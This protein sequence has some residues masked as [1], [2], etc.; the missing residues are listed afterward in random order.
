VSGVLGVC[1]DRGTVRA[2]Q[3]ARGQIVWVGTAPYGERAELV[4]LFGRLAADAPARPRRVRVVLARALVQVRTS[5]G[6]ALTTARARRYVALQA[7]QLFRQN[8]S[9]LVTDACV[10]AVNGDRVLVAAAAEEPLLTAVAQGCEQAGLTLESLGPSADVL[11]RALAHAPETG[12]LVFGHGETAELL[13][14]ERGTVW[15][16]RRLL[17]TAESA[18]EWAEPLRALGDQAPEFAEAFAA[19][20]RSPRLTLLPSDTRVARARA[21]RKRLGWVAVAA[22]VLWVLAGVTHVARLAGASRAARA[23]LV[24]LA[25]ALDSALAVRRELTLA[26]TA[27]GS[28]ERAQQSRSRWLALIAQLTEALD[29][30]VFAVTLTVSRDST[31]RITGYARQAAQALAAVDRMP[32]LERVRFEG[33]VARERIATG[34]G[35]AELDRFTIAGRVG[36]SR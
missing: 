25:P 18:H 34:A 26:L 10:H 9:V 22:V 23:E 3:L 32:S 6:T 31:I 13:E 30:S 16:S 24:A 14:L 11:P 5:T 27:L 19:A 15:Q 33:A 20:V 7:P 17:Q 4:D 28:L 36:G 2:V 1:V 21:A 12:T 8:G 35:V 29:D